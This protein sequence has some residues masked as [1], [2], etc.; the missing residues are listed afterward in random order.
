M[1]VTLMLTPFALAGFFV[2]LLAGSGPWSVVGMVVTGMI[3]LAG[4]YLV[5]FAV[6]FGVAYSRFQRRQSGR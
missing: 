2:L 5:L 4:L 1:L 3:A 6:V